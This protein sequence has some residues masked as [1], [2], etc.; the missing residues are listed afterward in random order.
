MTIKLSSYLICHSNFQSVENPH[1]NSKG[2]QRGAHSQST[3]TS[4]HYTQS[5][6]ASPGPS[7]SA[8]STPSR[9]RKP[10]TPKRLQGVHVTHLNFDGGK[11]GKWKHICSYSLTV[12][13][14]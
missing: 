10:K 5:G 3:I 8:T 7:D 1:A 13:N 6:E 4:I 9:A 12:I 14:D 2:N 11:E